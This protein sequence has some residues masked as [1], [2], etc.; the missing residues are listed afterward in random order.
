MVRV[1]K[2]PEFGFQPNETGER[3]VPT[4]RSAHA[5]SMRAA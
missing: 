4:I 1:G 2:G 3:A 5:R